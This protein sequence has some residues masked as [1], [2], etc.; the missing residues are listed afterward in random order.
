MKF[1]NTEASMKTPTLFLI[2]LCC[3]GC[4]NTKTLDVIYTSDW[5][6]E[7]DIAI[8]EECSKESVML[9]LMVYDLKGGVWTK[10]EVQSFQRSMLDGCVRHHGLDI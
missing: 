9:T 4:S 1:G 10:E 3:V 5:K 8:M 6:Q 7:H 2:L